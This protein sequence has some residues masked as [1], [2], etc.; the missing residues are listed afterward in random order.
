MNHTIG[1]CSLCGGR[2]TVPEHWYGVVPPTPECESCHA[3]A[4]NHGPTIP[5]KPRDHSPGS[6]NFSPAGHRGVVC[7]HGTLGCPGRGEKHWCAA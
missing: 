7:E 4:A 2:V 5:M 1:T 6:L 3:T